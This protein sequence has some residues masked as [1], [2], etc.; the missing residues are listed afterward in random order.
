MFSYLCPATQSQKG[1]LVKLK[2]A[3][4]KGNNKLTVLYPAQLR[5]YYQINADILSELS[6]GYS[7]VN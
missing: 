2:G 3:L 7:S 4:Q 6:I 5:A 1:E